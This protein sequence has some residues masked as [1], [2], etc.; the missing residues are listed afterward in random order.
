M[1][2]R[3][4]TRLHSAVCDT[5]IIIVKPPEG[6]GEIRCGGTPMLGLNETAPA[7]TALTVASDGGT[8][9]GKRYVGGDS[10]P[11]VLCTKAGAGSLT[12]GDTPLVEQGAKPLPPSD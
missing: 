11:E 5:E 4:G 7:N 3:P 2:L 1:E 10:G 12:F 6:P 9:L 8:L